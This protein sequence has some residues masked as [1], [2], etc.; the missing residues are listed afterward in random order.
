MG[1]KVTK[2]DVY[3]AILKIALIIFFVISCFKPFLTLDNKN[4]YLAHLFNPTSH[5]FSGE[6]ESLYSYIV[7][8]FTFIIL[9]TN[10]LPK[11]KFGEKG[12]I[13]L[14]SIKISIVLIYIFII[15][16]YF[17]V[18]YPNSFKVG[19]NTSNLFPGLYIFILFIILFII[20]ITL[21]A[22]DIKKIYFKN[23]ES[24]EIISSSSKKKKNLY[25]TNKVLYYLMTFS[26]VSLF[27]VPLF[28]NYTSFM[29]EEGFHDILDKRTSIDYYFLAMFDKS[30]TLT[31]P[32]VI[33]I[34]IAIYSPT[35][36]YFRNDNATIYKTLVIMFFYIFLMAFGVLIGINNGFTI[37]PLL[38]LKLNYVAIF[39][40]LL[41]LVSS[42]VI[43]LNSV[44]ILLINRKG[45]NKY[46]D[47]SS[48]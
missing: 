45:E 43:F 24:N 15:M 9:L 30:F 2:R 10:F 39:F 4:V 36:V 47:I 37:V 11:T 7:L 21:D 40:I 46:A 31:L 42:L 38:A 29:P 32:S 23:K 1:L 14:L 34:R 19:F 6:I 18:I 33:L 8:T 3:K 16:N 5:S 41:T 44:F 20:I 26:F 25:M 28:N 35:L 48:I 17:R 12:N 27:F 13:I 22:L